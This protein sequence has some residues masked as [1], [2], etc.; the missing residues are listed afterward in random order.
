MLTKW[1]SDCYSFKFWC[2]SYPERGGGTH[3]ISVC[4]DM[5][6]KGEYANQKGLILSLSGMG[7]CVIIK[8]SE[9]GY[10][11]R[12]TIG[13]SLPILILSVP[14]SF[15]IREVHG[16]SKKIIIMPDLFHVDF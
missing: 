4:R 3:Y 9:K 16:R 2:Y 1:N 14:G 5:L 13:T 12:D 8:K 7:V 6:I 11:C 15:R 10:G